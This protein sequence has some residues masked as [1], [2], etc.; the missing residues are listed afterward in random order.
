MYLFC[1]FECLSMPFYASIDKNVLSIFTFLK[2]YKIVLIDKLTDI[3]EIT[4]K[5][6]LIYKLPLL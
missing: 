4:W 5:K 3:L 6:L 2:I 1:F